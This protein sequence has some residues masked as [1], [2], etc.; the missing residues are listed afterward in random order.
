M[1]VNKRPSL[2]EQLK[3]LK[4]KLKKPYL[5]SWERHRIEQHIFHIQEM[6]RISSSQQ[7]KRKPSK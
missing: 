1:A 7:E 3:Q 4:Q 6:K 2:D 5:E